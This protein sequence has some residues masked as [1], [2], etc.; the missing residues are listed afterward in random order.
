MLF[1]C[2]GSGVPTDTVA[3]HFYGAKIG[4]F[5][6]IEYTMWSFV[7]KINAKNSDARQIE[8]STVGNAASLPR[9]GMHAEGETRHCGSKLKLLRSTM[10]RTGHRVESKDTAGSIKKYFL[11][12]KYKRKG[13]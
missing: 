7:V 4:I 12:L 6:R 5:F 11:H 13:L 8:A 2:V 10:G 9:H 3:F 1:L